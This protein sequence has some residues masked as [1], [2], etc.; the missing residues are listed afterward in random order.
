MSNGDETFDQHRP[1]ITEQD[2]IEAAKAKRVV[3]SFNA[4]PISSTTGTVPALAIKW[5]LSNGTTET[6]L[7]GHVAA[8]L[9][10]MILSHLEE[11]N[12][13]DLAALPPGATRQ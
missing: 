2:A 7:I 6:I 8:H 1:E 3:Q 10:R 11:N 13:T 5:K 4:H 12:W 9:L